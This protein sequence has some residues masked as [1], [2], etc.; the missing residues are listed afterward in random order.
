M[1]LAKFVNSLSDFYV[2]KKDKSDGVRFANTLFRHMLSNF[3]TD[4]ISLLQSL[5]EFRGG[6]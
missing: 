5:N 3:L 1:A 2:F 4:E 6:A